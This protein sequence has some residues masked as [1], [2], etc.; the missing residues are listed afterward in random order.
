MTPNVFSHWTFKLLLQEL[1]DP[2]TA[3]R[4]HGMRRCRAT[5]LSAE[6]LS[7]GGRRWV[8]PRWEGR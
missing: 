3:G 2:G 5:P 6:A 4:M 8:K 7:E 1:W